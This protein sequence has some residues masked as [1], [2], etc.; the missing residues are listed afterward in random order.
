MR[1]DSND[2]LGL[3]QDERVVAA[4]VRAAQSYGAGGQASRLA[5][6][7]FPLYEQLEAALA[8]AKGAEAACVFGSGYL[9]NLGAISALM[10]E[11]DLILADKLAHSCLLEGAKLS[12]AKLLR[13]K[14]NCT[15][16][17]AALLAKERGKHRNCLV[18]TEEIFSMDGDFGRVEEISAICKAHGAWLLVDGAHSIYDNSS[19]INHHSSIYV[20]TLSKALGGY[21]GY[22][23]GSAT[24]VK[25]IKTAA[26]TLIYSTALPP[27][28]VGAAI[29]AVKLAP[30][31][32]SALRANIAQFGA[33]SHIVPHIIGDEAKTLQAAE[34]LRQQGIL[35][36]AIR[37]PTVPPNTARL[38]ISLSAKHSAADLEK[39]KTA[40]KKVK[41]VLNLA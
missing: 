18:L 17:L 3:A 24:L 2:Y 22:V 19:F 16:H 33:Q 15:E 14:H 20:G 25:F 37:P 26:K 32:A 35:V 21:G 7:N 23:C 9:A 13:F 39:L 41:N 40:L 29:A 10:G 38:R 6:G 36:A 30:E 8:A 34:M 31:K 28:V 5:G 27:F 11:G 12:G 4:G 1:F